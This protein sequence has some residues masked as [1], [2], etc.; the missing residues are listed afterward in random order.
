MLS[1]LGY[2][3]TRIP[4]CFNFGRID[5]HGVASIELVFGVYISHSDATTVIDVITVVD[6]SGEG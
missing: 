2:V 5:G 4:L 1:A 6:S 3:R